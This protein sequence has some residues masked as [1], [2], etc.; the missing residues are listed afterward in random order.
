MA[1][2]LFQETTITETPV[3]NAYE[4]LVGEGKKFSDQESLAKG[5]L[6]SD[7]HISNLEQ[8][9]NE[10][11]E[12]L[13]KRITLDE[14]MTKMDERQTV[15]TSEEP[16]QNEPGPESKDVDVSALIQ[17]ELSKRDAV[18]ELDNNLSECVTK[19]Q[20]AW[21]N[22]ANQML[23][24]KAKEIGMPVGRL[25]QYA[26]NDPRVFQQL[27]GLNTGPAERQTTIAPTVDTNRMPTT[28]KG[29]KNYAYYEKMRQEDPRLYSDKKVQM[30]KHDAA[31]SMGSS[32]Y[33]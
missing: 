7:T 1:N 13:N 10:L 2:E 28:N 20:E 32:F 17:E 21:G 22:S 5:K 19:M 16:I 3:E 26:K 9:N 25:E 29:V 11:R 18:N 24:Q 31:M 4:T 27:L 6:E 30:E 33:D 8:E 23:N 14:F 15:S 12:D